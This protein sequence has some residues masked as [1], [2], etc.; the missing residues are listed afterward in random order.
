[1]A[2]D[3]DDEEA[4]PSKRQDSKPLIDLSTPIASNSPMA[5]L[6]QSVNSL[7][8]LSLR[9]AASG[10]L[11][12]AKAPRI[13]AVAVAAAAGGAGSG[14]AAGAAGLMDIDPQQPQPADGNNTSA[15]CATGDEPAR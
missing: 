1:M 13:M 4:A 12:A 8:S 3:S 2:C 14:G 9:R 7:S 11:L 10:Q 6:L 5:G 15:T